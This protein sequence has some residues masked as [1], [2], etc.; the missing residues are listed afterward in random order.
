VVVVEKRPGSGAHNQVGDESG[1]DKRSLDDLL[2]NGSSEDTPIQ[3]PRF[4]TKTAYS[5][6]GPAGPTLASQ[7]D[8][9]RADGNHGNLSL[10]LGKCVAGSPPRRSRPGIEIYPASRG[11]GAIWRGRRVVG[12]AT[13]D[14][15][16]ARD[17]KPRTPSPAA[18][19]C[20]PK[21]HPVGEGARAANSASALI[22]RFGPIATDSAEIRH[23]HQGTRE[24]ARRAQA[25]P[26]KTRSVAARKPHR[27]RVFLY[28]RRRFRQSLRRPSQLR[29][30]F[31]SPFEEFQRFK[32]NRWCALP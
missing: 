8:C 30:P 12:V 19:N 9:C 6:S 2:P 31:L 27:R 14:M 21:I 10:S 5:A 7:H 16:V 18:W 23:R 17:G 25:R 11:R 15:G 22:A 24:V 13:G 20:A 32:T 28:I 3:E 4:D 29:D 26:V 1:S